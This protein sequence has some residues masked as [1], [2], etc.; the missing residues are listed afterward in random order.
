MELVASARENEDVDSLPDLAERDFSYLAIVE[1]I[2][3][4]DERGFKLEGLGFREVRPMFGPVG[5]TL[6]LVPRKRNYCTP[7]NSAPQ[8]RAYNALRADRNPPY[9]MRL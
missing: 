2:V 1:A 5:L 6:L 4:R 8:G 9:T 7:N 3:D